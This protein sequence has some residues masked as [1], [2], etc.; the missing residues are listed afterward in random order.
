[1]I[2]DVLEWNKKALCKVHI[3]K[4]NKVC[5]LYILTTQKDKNPTKIHDNNKI[6]AYSR[7]YETK[8][9]FVV[10]NFSKKKVSYDIPIWAVRKILINNYDKLTVRGTTITLEPY[11]AVVFEEE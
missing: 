4:E 7:T 5:K 2:A 1:L 10:G 6:I 9:L 3:Y 11:Q 8:R